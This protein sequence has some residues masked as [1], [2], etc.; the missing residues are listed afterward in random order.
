MEK[1]LI[2]ILGQRSMVF[3][4]F[5][6]VP[7]LD[8]IMFIW[9]NREEKSSRHVAM[10]AKFLVVYSHYFKLH[11][12]YSISF[13]LANLGEIFSGTVSIVIQVCVVF[14]YM[15]YIKRACEIKK[16]HVV[17]VQRW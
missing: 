4:P 16:F 9:Q 12:S 17:V 13:K 5:S 14:S 2:G 10:V 11:R 15:Y 6:P 3:L 8:R 1:T 7:Q